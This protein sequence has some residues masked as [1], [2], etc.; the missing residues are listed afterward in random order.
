MGNKIDRH[1]PVC[2]TVYPADESRLRHGRQTTCSRACSYRLRGD[3]KK[4]RVSFRCAICEREFER[5]PSRVKGKYGAQFCSP[6]CHYSARSLGLS[7]R[8]VTEPYVHSDETLRKLSE[9]GAL[10]YASGATLRRPQSELDLLAYLATTG[11]KV[12]YQHVVKGERR[13]YVVDFYFPERGIVLELDGPEHRRS[14]KAQR[15]RDVDAILHGQGIRVHRI[16][17]ASPDEVRKAVDLAL[18]G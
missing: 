9:A 15:D 11:E 12:V 6:E 13:T 16:T 5:P 14:A 1:C 2:D 17:L 7:L 4:N 18:A 8:V 3:E 10:A